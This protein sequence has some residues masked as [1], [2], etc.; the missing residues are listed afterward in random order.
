MQSII[1]YGIITLCVDLFYSNRGVL[2]HK[3]GYDTSAI[4]DLSMAIAISP[5]L[6][7]VALFNRGIC[8]Q[9]TGDTEK[10][11]LLL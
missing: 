4:A 5:A 1:V 8:Y 7:S 9:A 3:M 10:V 6:S 2:R 11:L